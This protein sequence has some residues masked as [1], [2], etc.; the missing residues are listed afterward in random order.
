MYDN[1][2]NGKHENKN[3]N[4]KTKCLYKTFFVVNT[5]YR[6][7]ILLVCI[8]KFILFYFWYKSFSGY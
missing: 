7:N 6:T 2:D 3:A 5:I 8:L 1:G 4:V